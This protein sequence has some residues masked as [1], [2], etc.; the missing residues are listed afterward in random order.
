M[1]KMDS[2]KL[3]TVIIIVSMVILMLGLGAWALRL[4]I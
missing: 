2:V 4:G 3:L 1:L